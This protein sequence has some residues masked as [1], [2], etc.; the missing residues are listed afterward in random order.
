MGRTMFEPL[1]FRP[2]PPPAPPV[3][4][5]KFQAPPKP[6]PPMVQSIVPAPACTYCGEQWIWMSDR[7]CPSCGAKCKRPPKPAETQNRVLHESA[8]PWFGVV[9]AIVLILL[10][11]A[12]VDGLVALA[13]RGQQQTTST[14][15]ER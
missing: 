13:K 14:P 10:S 11:V 12:I 2:A 9:L 3:S 7:R 5:A 6:N 4:G 1:R 8:P 15:V